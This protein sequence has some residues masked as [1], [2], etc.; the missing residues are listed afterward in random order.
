MNVLEIIGLKQRRGGFTL[1]I[2]SLLLESDGTAH[3]LALTGA[4]GSGKST[5][6]QVAGLLVP[7][8]EAA[9]LTLAGQDV[10]A[11]WREGRAADLARLR[12]EFLGQSLQSQEVLD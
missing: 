7:P 3:W 5:L 1:A 4:S 9:A 6:L 12:R 11:L 2:E 10:V 8:M